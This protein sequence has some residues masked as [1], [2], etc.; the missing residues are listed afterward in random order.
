VVRPGMT[1]TAQERRAS[2][3][4]QLSSGRLLRYPGA[5]SP[6]TA[7]LIEEVGFDG[8]YVSGAALAADLALPDIGLT[9]LDEVAG[10]SG[11]IAAATDLPTIV[12]ADTGFGEPMNVA[13]TIQALEARGLAGCHLEDQVNPKRCGHLDGKSVVPIDEMVRRVRA[14]VSARTDVNFVVCART[15]ARAV[16][17]LDAAIDRARA[18]VDA[19]AD[20]VFPE[21]LEG[22]AE[23]AAFRAAI[24]VPLLAN[25]TEFGKSP[26]LSSAALE[27]L[28]VNLVIYPVTLLR[29][30]MGAIE[31][32][33]RTI[34]AEGTQES[35]VPSMQ[36]RKRLYELLHY[37]DYS[38]FDADIVSFRRAQ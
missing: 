9:T 7:V 18:Y 1:T 22:E 4:E 12:D 32:G 8:C 35:L 16:E 34:L 28:G 3:R 14:A 33:L 2:L 20:M 5:I 11:Q 17:G 30:A 25:M 21:A 31:D 23:L 24:D 10:R 27:S 29:L 37:D 15:D 6:L 36:S 38:A 19:G 26:L 13:R